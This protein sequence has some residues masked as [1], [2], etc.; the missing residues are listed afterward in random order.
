[1]RQWYIV[2]YDISDPKRLHHVMET[3]RD[4][5]DRIQLS[6]FLCQLSQKDLVV[7]RERLRQEINA[8]EDQI[9]FV[10]LGPAGD[11]DNLASDRIDNLGRPT[12]ISDSRT[13][14][15]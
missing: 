11:G 7:L 9:L 6:V 3:T 10:R 15:F 5:G 14:I 12:E 4:F 2:M 8:N 1:M 13:F